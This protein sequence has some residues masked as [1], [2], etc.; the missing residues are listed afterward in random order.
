MLTK[1]KAEIPLGKY[2]WRR[3]TE[4]VWRRKYK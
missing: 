3:E 1:T 4:K 2:Y